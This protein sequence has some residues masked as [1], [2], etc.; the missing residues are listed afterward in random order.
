MTVGQLKSLLQK[1]F[2]VPVAKQK[3]MFKMDEQSL[4]IPLEDDSSEL[5]YYGL[6]VSFPLTRRDEL[7]SSRHMHKLFYM[8]K[9]E[10]M[11]GRLHTVLDYIYFL[12]DSNQLFEHDGYVRYVVC[13]IKKKRVLSVIVIR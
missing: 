3:L 13:L 9:T 12:I 8:K 5:S 7:T 6:Q 10:G 11:G 4:P 2:K 1:K